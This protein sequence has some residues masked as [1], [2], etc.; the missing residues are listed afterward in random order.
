MKES[1]V[2]ASHCGGGTHDIL[3]AA[4]SYCVPRKTI[5]VQGSKKE[6]RGLGFMVTVVNSSIVDEGALV[7]KEKGGRRKHTFETLVLKR[8]LVS[9]G[10]K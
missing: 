3:G 2:V 9:Q 6:T 7:Y 1:P 5:H 4:C 10:K 8:S